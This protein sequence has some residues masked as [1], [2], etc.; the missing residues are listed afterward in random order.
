MKKGIHWRRY[1]IYLAL[2]GCYIHTKNCSQFQSRNPQFQNKKKVKNITWVKTQVHSALGHINVTLDDSS[3]SLRKLSSVKTGCCGNS[4]VSSPALSSFSK[5]GLRNVTF[6]LWRS[7]WSLTWS[8]TN[9]QTP[10]C[11]LD[12]DIIIYYWWFTWFWTNM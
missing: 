2:K 12:N 4:K 1:V 6:T 8:I 11:F 10:F 9:E 5:C 3:L 7:F